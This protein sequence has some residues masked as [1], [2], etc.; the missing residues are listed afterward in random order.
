MIVEDVK[1]GRDL[2]NEFEKE[3]VGIESE[4]AIADETVTE[5]T[6][7]G[8]EIGTENEVF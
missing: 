6:E 7:N 1:T 8:I 3:I 4:N 5:E 2:P